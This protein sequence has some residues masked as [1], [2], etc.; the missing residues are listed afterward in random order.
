[1]KLQTLLFALSLVALIDSCS[2]SVKRKQTFKVK[3]ETAESKVQRVHSDSLGIDLELPKG[4]IPT[5]I[6]APIK[7]VPF[8]YMDSINKI[9]IIADKESAFAEKTSLQVMSM[10]DATMELNENYLNYTLSLMQVDGSKLISESKPLHIKSKNGKGLLVQA[11]IQK[12]NMPTE[13]A[14]CIGIF[15]TKE[16][17]YKFIFWTKASQAKDLYSK[18]QSILKSI[19][20]E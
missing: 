20:F 7:E 10:Y 15:E 17:I 11:N 8:Q 12:L 2:S 5:T 9:Y 16:N 14:Y 1:M 4:L 6:L 18:T 19:T 13:I 3:A